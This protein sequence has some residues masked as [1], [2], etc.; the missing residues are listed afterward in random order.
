MG[1]G[2]GRYCRSRQGPDKLRWAKEE[3][4]RE[5]GRP[6]E[7]RDPAVPRTPYPGKSLAHRC[8]PRQPPRLLYNLVTV[9]ASLLL[10]FLFPP[11]YLFHSLDL[12]H[13]GQLSLPE[14]K[15][16]GRCDTSLARL[17]TVG[18]WLQTSQRNRY[19]TQA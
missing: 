1:S 16:G 9:Q 7:W 17:D 8:A 18:S 15:V 5:R 3:E 4:E 14:L 2:Q 6:Q 19:A 10:S 11:R 13:S 12:D